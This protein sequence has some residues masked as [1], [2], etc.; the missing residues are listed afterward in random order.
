MVVEVLLIVAFL[1]NQSLR[2]LERMVGFLVILQTQHVLMHMMI[3]A[4]Q[5]VV[6]QLLAIQEIIV[7]D[8]Q[9]MLK[10]IELQRVGKVLIL[11]EC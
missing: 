3:I 9:H 1:V 10:E 6:K 4:S 8:M 11:R 2:G 5:K 7:M